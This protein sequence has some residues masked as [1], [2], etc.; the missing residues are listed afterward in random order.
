MIKPEKFIKGI[1][2][3][4]L[5][6]FAASCSNEK[7]PSDKPCTLADSILIQA[8][9]QAKD[10]Q[11]MN[12]VD[13]IFCSNN[14]AIYCDYFY[15]DDT[16]KKSIAYHKA[17]SARYAAALVRDANGFANMND[18]NK[19]FIN[20]NVGRPGDFTYINYCKYRRSVA[21]L[22]LIRQE[23]KKHTK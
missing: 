6:T 8:Q 5:L 10:L 2:L 13:Y 22:N 4:A 11:F 17:D 1:G 7:N 3:T 15:K 18:F 16:A 20:E 19:I 14:Q 21:L 23:Q 9:N 12:D